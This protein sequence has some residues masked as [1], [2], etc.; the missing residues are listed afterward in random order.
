MPA[1]RYVKEEGVP[2]GPKISALVEHVGKEFAGVIGGGGARYLIEELDRGVIGTMPA[3]ELLDLPVALL[4]AYAAGKR[5]RAVEIYERSLPLLLIQAPYR[6]RMTKLI[7]KHRGIIADDTCREPLPSMDDKLKALTLE[8]FDRAMTTLE[9][10]V[11]AG[12]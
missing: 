10:P 11:V 8:F 9:A 5:D 7:L 6:M 3:I 2:S 1:I 4:A 12:G